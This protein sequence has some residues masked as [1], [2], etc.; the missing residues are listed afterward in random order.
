MSVE[1]F[2]YSHSFIHRGQENSAIG[3]ASGGGSVMTSTGGTAKMS[4]VPRNPPASVPGC[5][6]TP[7]RKPV[8]LCQVS[9]VMFHASVRK[10][11]HLHH[12]LHTKKQVKK[13]VDLDEPYM[14]K[15]GLPRCIFVI[16]L[17]FF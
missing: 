13:F 1:C 11:V 9:F 17:I 8:R 2:V 10:I 16:V 12:C 4:V 15:Q 7:S 5:G 3:V 14:K 6:D